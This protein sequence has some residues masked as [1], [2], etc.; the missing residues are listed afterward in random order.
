MQTAVTKDGFCEE[1]AA[2]DSDP[3]VRIAPP[4]WTAPP[5]SPPRLKSP[6]GLSY[7]VLA[8][9]G[10]WT[11]D[12]LVLFVSYRLGSVAVHDLAIMFGGLVWFACAV[13]FMVWFHRVRVN[14]EVFAPFGHRKSRG[15][16]YW[17]WIVP[18]VNLWYPRRIAVDTW[19]AST[20]RRP[21]GSALPASYR[22]VNVWWACWLLSSCT[23]YYPDTKV[24]DVVLALGTVADVAAAV[25]AGCFV[26]Q[27]TCKQ[28]VLVRWGPIAAAA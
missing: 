11:A 3:L 20:Q 21:D 16:A 9:L 28:D 5:G 4:T 12:D 22:L 14:A 13:T 6:V 18:V 1:C 15:W 7:A 23:A 19:V 26:R 2:L 8:L 25:A 10:V 17:G 27:L 24:Q